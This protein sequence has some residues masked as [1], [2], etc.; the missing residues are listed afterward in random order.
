MSMSWQQPPE[1]EPL[2]A[3]SCEGYDEAQ[4]R[5]IDAM[6]EEEWNAALAAGRKPKGWAA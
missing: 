5:L 1:R 3:E 4:Q 2:P 6:S